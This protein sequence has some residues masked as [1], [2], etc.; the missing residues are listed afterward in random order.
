L[1]H[2]AFDI[3]FTDTNHGLMTD[4]TREEVD[5]KPAAV[6][7]KVEARLAHLEMIV[8]TGFA[9]VR[10]EMAAMRTEM[11]QMRT[12]MAGMRTEMH[13]TIAALIKWAFALAVAIVSTTVGLLTHLR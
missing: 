8:R 3:R 13:K 6:E 5:A 2:G 11:A 9:E 1:I 7:A 10:A 12:E 4:I